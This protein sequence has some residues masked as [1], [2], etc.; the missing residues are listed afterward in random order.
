V[1][2]LNLVLGP[3]ATA[4]LQ[5]TAAREQAFARTANDAL[6]AGKGSKPQSHTLP[7]GAKALWHILTQ[8]QGMTPGRA[9]ALGELMASKASDVA[10]ELRARQALKGTKADEAAKFQSALSPALAG[11]SGL[12]GTRLAGVGQNGLNQ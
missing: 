1:E 4:K 2:H 10:D 7:E 5:E 12:A 8:P 3:E 6:R 11:L 9:N